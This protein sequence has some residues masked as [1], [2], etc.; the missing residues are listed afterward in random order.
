MKNIKWVLF[1]LLF[2]CTAQAQIL[3]VDRASQIKTNTSNFN[4]T[5]SANETTVQKAL[6][7]LDDSVGGGAS[8]IRYNNIL[9]PN[10]V[11]AIGFGTYTNTWTS[12]AGAAPFIIFDTAGLDN[13]IRGDGNV[14]I[15]TTTPTAPLDVVGIAKA[16]TFQGSGSGLSNIAYNNL[17]DAGTYSGASFGTYTQ[18]WTSAAQGGDFFVIKNPQ[19][20]KILVVDGKGAIKPNVYSG[21]M[22]GKSGVSFGTF[23]NAWT[24]TAGAAPFMTFD[25]ATLDDVV[26][27]D[28]NVGIGTTTPAYGLQVNTADVGL[29]TGTFD[30]NS[31]NEDLYVTG[32]IEADGTIYGNGIGDNVSVNGTAATDADFKD[33]GV[34]WSRDVGGGVGGLDAIRSTVL[35]DDLSDPNK[36]AGTYFG[37]FT[38]S[39]TFTSGT[40]SWTSTAGAAARFFTVSGTSQQVVI[41]G[42]GNLGVG[43]TNPTQSLDIRGSI[44]ASTLSG[45][46][47]QCLQASNLGVV[48]GT[49]SAC[50]SGGGSSVWSALTSPTADLGLVMGSFTNAWTSSS[51]IFTNTWTGAATTRNFFSLDTKALTTGNALQIDTGHSTTTGNAIVVKNDGTAVAYIDGDGDLSAKSLTATTGGLSTLQ[52]GLTVN[53]D[54]GGGTNYNTIIWGSAAGQPILTFDTNAMT[55]TMPGGSKFDFTNA[56]TVAMPTKA[57]CTSSIQNGSFCWT[58]SAL[59]IGNG[60]TAVS[61]GSG[62]GGGGSTSSLPINSITDATANSSRGYGAFTETWTANAGGGTFFKIQDYASNSMF[63]VDNKGGIHP[64]V[65]SGSMTGNSGV[66][67]GAFNNSWTFTTGTNTWTATGAAGPFFTI[68][69]SKA[70][71]I[72]ADGN[73]GIGVTA[74]TTALQ[75][76]SGGGE[77]FQNLVNCDTIDTDVNGTLACGTDATGGSSSNPTYNQILGATA[78][79]GIGFG[80]FNNTW[81]SSTSGTQL[82]T[83]SGTSG[84]FFVLG[85]A[86]TGTIARFD[87]N[88]T[89]TFDGGTVQIG[90]TTSASSIRFNNSACIAANPCV[91]GTNAYSE[92]NLW[93]SCGHFF[94]YCNNTTAKKMDG[95][96]A[97]SY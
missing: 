7:V 37:T 49:G 38:N 43:N 39:W 41:D 77:R 35:F 60:S 72:R 92:G 76:G 13:A 14:G 4:G 63:T 85:D 25:T 90:N 83:A 58:G 40:N 10:A 66:N 59:T 28:G 18:T 26:R 27:G 67:F 87:R 71:V 86:S 62:G 45:S 55:A 42:A 79:A 65:Y 24:S 88:G 11:S 36:N 82:W 21:T 3:P 20:T 57:S 97:C 31:A 78:N 50:G 74:P 69:G 61:I 12:T 6:D 93:Y 19:G 68:A 95:S 5:L 91:D 34:T 2:S 56:D 32:N 48:S 81:T 46:G 70:V 89:T 47:T 30:H 53:T 84:Q 22:N 54:K 73:V 51:A 29:G 8:S 75:V 1:I 9:S 33:G 64:S 23:T 80:T 16:T 17:T 15:G 94:C 96:T 44:K 52:Q